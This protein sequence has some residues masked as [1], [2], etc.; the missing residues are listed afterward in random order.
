MIHHRSFLLF[1]SFFSSHHCVT[2]FCSQTLKT[3]RKMQASS[4]TSS[5]LSAKSSAGSTQF[6]TNKMCPYAQKALIALESSGT[7][8]EIREVSLYGP[9]GKPDWFWAL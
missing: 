3:S 5:K 2:S 4:N 9:G 6:I 7:P 8:F 1:L